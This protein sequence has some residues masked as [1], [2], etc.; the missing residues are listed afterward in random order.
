MTKV[1]VVLIGEDVSNVLGDWLP[2]IEA[3]GE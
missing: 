1:D 3:L 2:H